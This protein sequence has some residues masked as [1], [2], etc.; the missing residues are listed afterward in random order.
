M[1]VWRSVGRGLDTHRWDFFD[2]TDPCPMI[3]TLIWFTV[4]DTLEMMHLKGGVAGQLK[5]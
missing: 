1:L 4:T 3:K 2:I 5:E